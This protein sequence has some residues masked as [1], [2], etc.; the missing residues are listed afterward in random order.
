MSWDER[1]YGRGNQSGFGKPG[2]DWQGIRPS[3][4][5][6]M[7]WSIPI[8]RYFGIDVRVH[9][10]MLLFIVIEL[11]RAWLT[12]GTQFG[13]LYQSVIMG[14]LFI[15]VLLHE[16][17]HC[18]ACRSVGG[19]A[20]EIL[21]WPL[22]GLAYCNPPNRWRAH[23]WTAVGG[24][25]VNVVFLF[26][27]GGVLGLTTGQWM[28]VAVPNP[29]GFPSLWWSDLNTQ[30]WQRILYLV[31]NINMILLL[32]NVLLPLFPLDGGRITQSLLWSKIGYVKSMRLA[33]RIG[34]FGA[35]V[36]GIFGIVIQEIILVCIAIFGGFTC[37]MTHK[38]LEFTQDMMG[39]DHDDYTMATY[40]QGTDNKP[41]KPKG[42]SKR[43]LRRQK[44]AEEAE[45]R[46]R[47]ELD[48]LLAKIKDSGMSSLSNR[49]QKWLKSQ[50]KRKQNEN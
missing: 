32:F 12:S 50:S 4:D 2:G 44:K 30:E 35:I 40:G 18:F 16:F 9:I 46:D 14:S 22:G 10:I 34:Y 1:N 31:A 5:N 33:L 41:T 15:L 23:F 20:D 39:F 6:P 38:Q 37:W 19:T 28:G 21:M 47:K 42:P 11:F 27:F 29:L 3:F 13:L 48:R 24:P 17:G 26:I 7:S 45:A 8:G 49:E 25:L 36:L 43:E